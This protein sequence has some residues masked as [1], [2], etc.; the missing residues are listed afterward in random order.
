[1]ERRCSDMRHSDICLGALSLARKS[2]RHPFMFCLLVTV[3]VS[4]RSL[5]MGPYQIDDLS[6]LDG[7]NLIALCALPYQEASTGII[8]TTPVPSLCSLG[9]LALVT[10]GRAAQALWLFLILLTAALG[11]KELLTQL[12]F[13]PSL[14]LVGAILYQLS[15]AVFNQISQGGP[16]IVLT[17]ALMPAIIAPLLPVAAVDGGSSARR[18]IQSGLLMALAALFN[19]QVVPLAALFLIGAFIFRIRQNI[20]SATAT[21]IFMVGAF[22]LGAMPILL[23]ANATRLRISAAAAEIVRTTGVSIDHNGPEK[24]IHAYFMVALVPPFIALMGVVL[25]WR[26]KPIPSALKALLTSTFLLLCFWSLFQIYGVEMVSAVPELGLFR[27]SI[28]FEMLLGIPIVALTILFLDR[29]SWF[30]FTLKNKRSRLFASVIVLAVALM[31]TV[32]SSHGSLLLG[33]VGPPPSDRFPPS[34]YKALKLIHKRDPRTRGY[35]ILWLPQDQQ[36]AYA[37][38]VVDTQS[39]LMRS[40]LAPA[41]QNAILDAWGSIIAKEENEIAPML[42]YLDVKYVVINRRYD[43]VGRAPWEMGHPMI[44]PI[45]NLELLSGNSP[46]YERIFRHAAHMVLLYK[47]RS[48]VVFKNLDFVP[49]V[50]TF[51]AVVG[52]ISGQT[53]TKASLH[54]KIPR[55]SVDKLSSG[56]VQLLAPTYRLP[57][58]VLKRASP[59]RWVILDTRHPVAQRALAGGITVPANNA[60]NG[61]NP[62]VAYLPVVAG[63]DYLTHVEMTYRN[64]VQSHAKIIWSGSAADLIIPAYN[65]NGEKEANA[66]VV[67]PPD[68]TRAQILLMG[69]WRDAVGKPGFTRYTRVSISRAI[70][71][72]G[73]DELTAFPSVLRSLQRT[74]PD[75]LLEPSLPEMEI[76]S[77]LGSGYCFVNGL[78]FPRSA[79]CGGYVSLLSGNDLRLHGAWGSN[80]SPMSGYW[81]SYLSDSQ[82]SYITI[83]WRHQNKLQARLFWLEVA[84]PSYGLSSTVRHSLQLGEKSTVAIRCARPR[85]LVV[86]PSVVLSGPKISNLG[87]VVRFGRSYAARFLLPKAP[88]FHPPG[89]WTTILRERPAALNLLGLPVARLRILSNAISLAVIVIGLV[90][91]FTGMPRLRWRK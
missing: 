47:D 26:R 30:P 35:R 68:A 89:D 15:P 25:L 82:G 19:P 23:Q 57:I 91:S 33:G 50:R 8:N 73:I 42:G 79:K 90:L 31:P 38:S 83:R 21:F 51:S 55:I 28:K 22:A 58:T 3:L 48:I 67:A 45:G 16:G 80:A 86:N 71:H 43:P 37:L 27:D 5:L 40:G 78:D 17:A 13:R 9:A 59:R 56:G 72:P 29:I 41:A 76:N 75:Y 2:L 39:L 44:A 62:A 46:A 61:W 32:I 14:A 36:L 84:A 65:G 49:I 4:W 87:P 88:R 77:H 60:S 20:A 7:R 63:Q 85:C 18:G 81:S 53:W 10:G 1:M 34:Y 64:V 74:L 69:G 24:L 12:G 11:M 70:P 6:P 52:S 66:L 54:I